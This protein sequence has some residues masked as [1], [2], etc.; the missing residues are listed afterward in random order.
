MG[1]YDLMMRLYHSVFGGNGYNTD[2]SI[3]EKSPDK[4]DNGF[5]V[6]N[7]GK[8]VGQLIEVSYLNQDTSMVARG[9]LRFS[10]NNNFFYV[11]KGND[12][13]AYFIVY[14]HRRDETGKLFAVSSIR[15]PNGEMIYNN[16]DVNHDP[17]AAEAEARRIQEVADRAK[18]ERDLGKRLRRRDTSIDGVVAGDPIPAFS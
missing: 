12:D 13:N 6:D 17:V 4:R 7:L 18:N 10:P 2:K 11:T 9:K 1:T 3:G 8:Y 15:A 14:W 16:L 5:P